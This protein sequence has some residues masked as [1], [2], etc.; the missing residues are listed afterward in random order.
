MN[1]E[2]CS[3]CG[4]KNTY[5]IK[6]PNFCG[7]CGKPLGKVNQ[8]A[9]TPAKSV[10]RRPSAEE[11]LE[12]EV[13]EEVPDISKLEYE[14]DN[15]FGGGKITIGD[16]VKEGPSQGGARPK[17]EPGESKKLSREEI[18]AESLKS[19]KSAKTQ[20]PEEID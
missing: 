18:V 4:Y 2:Y 3:K 8:A 13:F 15:S 12:E 6:A 10:F 1:V 19:C 16:L 17:K 7:G 9:S 11:V 5:T 20:P 14:I